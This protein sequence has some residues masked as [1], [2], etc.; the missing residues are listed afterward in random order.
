MDFYERSLL[1]KEESVL[2]NMT[3]E[4]QMDYEKQ[5]KE[6]IMQHLTNEELD[7][8]LKDTINLT[9]LDLK[10]LA[11][12]IRTKTIEFLESLNI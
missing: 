7:L 10:D 9:S 2:D 3:Y 5:K 12:L 4:Q 11:G 6:W 1:G 8:Y